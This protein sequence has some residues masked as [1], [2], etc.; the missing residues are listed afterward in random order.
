MHSLK[1]TPQD[2]FLQR[3]KNQKSNQVK[4]KNA[5]A[6]MQTQMETIKMRTDEA[7]E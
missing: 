6:K 2:P 1:K 5:V 3:E 4:I 7:E